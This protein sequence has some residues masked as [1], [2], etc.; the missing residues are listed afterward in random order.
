M[1][2]P[3]KV[4]ISSRYLIKVKFNSTTKIVFNFSVGS[5]ELYQ[6]IPGWMQSNGKW[7]SALREIIA[8]DSHV[9][10]SSVTIQA[11]IDY[12]NPCKCIYLIIIIIVT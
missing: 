3:W 2:Q 11:P 1:S 8:A 5:V 9:L 4:L 7:E 6:Q 10:K 12:F